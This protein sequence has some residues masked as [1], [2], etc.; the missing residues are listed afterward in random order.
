MPQD[1]VFTELLERAKTTPTRRKKKAESKEQQHQL[2]VEQN[3]QRIIDQ[4]GRDGHSFCTPAEGARHQ[5]HPQCSEDENILSG[6]E[7]QDA[8]L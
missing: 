8:S 5:R 2:R 3:R 6:S 1:P 7:K 4:V